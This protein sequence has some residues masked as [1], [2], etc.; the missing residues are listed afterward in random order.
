VVEK[1]RAIQAE[2]LIE[3]EEGPLSLVLALCLL[4]SRVSIFA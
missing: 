4:S 3:D 2:K 1:F